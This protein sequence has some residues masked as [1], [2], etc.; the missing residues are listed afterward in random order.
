VTVSAGVAVLTPGHD[1]IND[2]VVEA[3]TA[4]YRAKAAGKNRVFVAG[5]GDRPSTFSL[6]SAGS[7]V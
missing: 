5:S 4:L 6:Y 3:D 1:S 2:L 7:S